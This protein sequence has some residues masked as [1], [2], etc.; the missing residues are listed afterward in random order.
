[1][2]QGGLFFSSSRIDHCL[3][4]DLTRAKHADNV[5]SMCGEG[6]LVLLLDPKARFLSL[7][8]IEMSTE[9]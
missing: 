2:Y 1:M 6:F 8:V 5:P 9:L 7:N 3:P 4:G